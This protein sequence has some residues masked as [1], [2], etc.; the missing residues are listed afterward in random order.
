MAT[1]TGE[2]ASA[3]LVPS[4]KIVD[5]S[6]AAIQVSKREMFKPT[7]M[8]SDRWP[9]NEE[10]WNLLFGEELVGRLGLFHFLQRITKTLRKRH[11]DYFMAINHLLDA[12]YYYEEGDYERLIVALKN[13]S[14]SATAKK[15]TDAEIRELKGTKYF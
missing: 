14:L 4:T 5:L 13:G 11:V 8:Y 3:V 15:Y 7:A 6:H 12:V 2:I 9:T 10:Y 1:E